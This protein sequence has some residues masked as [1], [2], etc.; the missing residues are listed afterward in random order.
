MH[1][2]FLF[3]CLSYSPCLILSSPPAVCVLPSPFSVSRHL[4]EGEL[5]LGDLK[6]Q[7][8]ARA[9]TYKQLERVTQSKQAEQVSRVVHETGEHVQRADSCSHYVK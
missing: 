4:C 6:R 9:S 2:P 1:A 8:L 5:S 3:H 7:L